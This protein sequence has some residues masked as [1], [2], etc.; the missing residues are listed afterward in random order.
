MN[1]SIYAPLASNLPK[2]ASGVA[3][4]WQSM[5]RTFASDNNAP[6][7]AE[8]LQALIAANAGDA[9]GYGHDPYTTAAVERVRA[10][11]GADVDV[12]F[13][14]NGTGANVVA[15]SAVLRPYH[16]VIAPVSAHLNVDE[17]GALERFAGCKIIAIDAADGKLH[18][19]DL[20]PFPAAKPDAH[21]VWPH[22]ISISQATEFGTLYT[23]D[24]LRELCAFAHERDWLV[25]LDGARIANAAAAQG[26]GLRAATRD[27]GVDLLTLGGTKNGLMFGEAVIFFNPAQHG[28]GAEFARKQTTQLPSKMRYIAAQFDALL[29]DDRWRTYARHA[30]AMAARLATGIAKIV[31]VTIT[32]PVEINAVF[33]TLDRAAIARLQAEFYFYVL[34]A[35]R[36][37]V[38]WMTSHATREQDVDAFLAALTGALKA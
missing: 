16:A 10:E 3:R 24:E 5:V 27:L 17:C 18:P 31:G 6:V 28:G 8:I 36:P 13:A 12:L 19:A 2:G 23:P 11:F 32:R 20:A 37:E 38:R 21:H 33:A 26:L 15:L 9:V 22:V 25:H 35:V 7:A 14:F 34:D 30:N 1:R 29:T 4:Y